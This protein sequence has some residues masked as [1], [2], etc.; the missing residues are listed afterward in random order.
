MNLQTLLSR[1]DEI[2]DCLVWNSTIG[3]TGY[4]IIH[5]PDGCR[6]ARRLAFTLSGGVLKQRQPVATTC[7]DKRCI[8]P[9]HLRAS[10][11][12]KIAQAAARRGAYSTRARGAKIAAARRN[13]GA[14]LTEALAAEIRLSSE[15]GRVLADRYGVD[16]SLVNRIKRGTAWRDYSSPFAGLVRRVGA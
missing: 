11:T 4:P 13:G 8:N 7:G 5:T 6:L 16:K 9:E 12:A 1:T 3:T 2:G 10:T 14:K 15:P